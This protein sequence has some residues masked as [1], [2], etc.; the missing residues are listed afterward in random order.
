M[1]TRASTRPSSDATRGRAAKARTEAK[2]ARFS[3]E[4]VADPPVDGK[5]MG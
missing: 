4:R 3:G 1:C 5:P 2:S